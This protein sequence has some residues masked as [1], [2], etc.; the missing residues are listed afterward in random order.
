MSQPGMYPAPPSRPPRKKPSGWWIVAGIVVIVAGIVGAVT[1][2]VGGFTRMT[3]TVDHFQRV[4]VPGSG[5]LQLSAGHDY[6]GYLEFSG[7]SSGDT[8][9]GVRVR[10]TGP[11]GQVVPM[12]DYGSNVT[13]QMGGHEGRAEFSFRVGQDG[14]YHLL[15]DGGPDVTVAV[16]GGLGSSIAGTVVLALVLGLGG[17]FPGI[18]VVV[19]VAVLRS[20]RSRPVAPRGFGPPTPPAR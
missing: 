19:I 12:H 6:T 11:D 13:Y 8:S 1:V 18:A 15:T 17:I 5:D 7:A 16:G 3:N 9:Q 2:G 4:A 20:I 14:Q 10:L